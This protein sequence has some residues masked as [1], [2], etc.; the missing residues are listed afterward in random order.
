MQTWLPQIETVL[1]AGGTSPTDFTLHDAEHAER[2]AGR[3]A[4]IIGPDLLPQLSS[5]DL[6]HLL[7]SAYLHDIGMTPAQAK[8]QNHH[9]YLLTGTKSLLTDEER[10][11]FQRW[12]DETADGVVPPLSQHAPNQEVL[13]QAQRLTTLYCR[14]KHNDW[15]EEW[16]RQNAPDTNSHPYPAFL[17]DLI[18]LCKS[19]H[20][21]ERE[22]LGEEFAPRHAGQ[23]SEVVHLRYLACVL[24]VAD[25]L[26]IDPER[27][28]GILLAH[29]DVHPASRIFWHKDLEISLA[30][31][32][33]RYVLNARP[34]SALIHKAVN[35][36]IDQINAELATCK[37]LADSTHFDRLPG[38]QDP[39]PHKWRL[40]TA[41]HHDVRP[42]D[43]AY[44][45]IEG[46]F[47][48]NT[49]RLLE[50]LSGER[51]YGS[52]LVAVRE[53]LQ[54]AFDAVREQAAYERLADPRPTDPKTAER[55][56]ASHRVDIRLIQTD[57]AWWLRCKDDG[58]GMHKGIIT[59]HLLISG[60]P[61]HYKVRELERKCRAAGFNLGRTGRFGIG[62][63]SYFMLADRVEIR[64]RRSQEAEDAEL[65]GWIFTTDGVGSFG[66][67]R[68]DNQLTRGTEV[69][70]RLRDSV[71]AD[72]RNWFKQLTEFV[73]QNLAVC[74]CEV[75]ISS[76]LPG[77]D[78]LVLNPGWAR[79]DTPQSC[80]AYVVARI[81][82][83]ASYG[84]DHN[85]DLLSSAARAEISSHH[86]ACD[87]LDTSMQ[88]A[89]T[90]RTVQGTLPSDLGTYRVTLL[91]FELRPGF[92]LAYCTTNDSTPPLSLQR[93][94]KGL[95]VHM[96]GQ[97]Q[98]S[99]KGFSFEPGPP[100]SFRPWGR[101]EPTNC[102]IEIDLTDDRAGQ[103]S[104][105][106]RGVSL[107][108]EGASALDHVCQVAGE[109][110]IR[111]V[112]DHD[113]SPFGLLNAR[114]ADCQAPSAAPAWLRY[115][116]GEMTKP[117][118]RA[119]KWPSVPTSA[120]GYEQHPAP[121]MFRGRPVNWIPSVPPEDEDDHYD[122]VPF[123]PSAQTPDVVVERDKY[124]IA[125]AP[126]WRSNPLGR[127]TKGVP[128]ASFPS[129]WMVL[130]ASYL[131]HSFN[132]SYFVLN[133]RH[134]LVRHVTSE[135]W[136]TSRELARVD[137]LLD[138]KDDILASRPLAV[139]FLLRLVQHRTKP[140]WEGLCERDL[141]F[142]QRLWK[143]CWGRNHAARS[144]YVFYDPHG[145]TGACLVKIDSTSWVNLW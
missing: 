61:K 50:L 84:D 53:L 14:A 129:N 89:L 57:G 122:G 112:Q 128:T 55:V 143:L 142:V 87:Q 75:Q 95:F 114:I 60:Q 78:A 106:R 29:R 17:H 39:L 115:D 19:H 125:M 7:L 134:S 85:P 108:P 104:V 137:D 25:V 97:V 35:E 37:R 135:A 27:T 74:P 90:T 70:F 81:R 86:E 116:E 33:D 2:V 73:R 94:N 13:A 118:W 31:D 45:Y 123:V 140:I 138:A 68:L 28:P 34:K 109:S 43:D 4:E 63:L 38:R 49:E 44:E 141:S 117:V 18:R 6:T 110:L 132:S 105:D 51:L 124:R 15:S 47:R 59:D 76:D 131:P 12:L 93:I 133:S 56:A 58:V 40:A 23:P 3:M 139:S 126:L 66:E 67:L 21:S 32:D 20:L 136:S 121:Q 99:W 127:P 9:R 69:S 101:M 88:A 144:L 130:A 1:R 52:S 80:I 64:T 54:N 26:D 71:S 96:P 79:K 103:I 77:C 119:L 83:H 46:S 82:R 8:V 98:L 107:S 62:V 11:D 113:S 91:G 100:D 41:V 92:S 72:P 120:F 111:L 42:L 48:P 24:R 36:T 22:L 102:A 65:N 5:L 145:G 10:R 16:I 30:L